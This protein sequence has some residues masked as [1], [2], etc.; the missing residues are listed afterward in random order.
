MG[1]KNKKRKLSE[2]D[3]SRRFSH[4]P[5][6]TAC[7]MLNLGRFKDS[8]F[9]RL[10]LEAVQSMDTELDWLWERLREVHLTMGIE[11]WNEM[12]AREFVTP[13]LRSVVLELLPEFENLIY[14]EA[15][16]VGLDKEGRVD[17]IIKSGDAI[18]LVI[19]VKATEINPG[20][21]QN[22]AQIAAARDQNLRNGVELGDTMF[23]I[24]TTG[25]DWV[26]MKVVF[27]AD[28]KPAVSVSKGMTLSIRC[29][30]LSKTV[31]VKEFELLRGRIMRMM[32][33]QAEKLQGSG[34]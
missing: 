21:A 32:K 1:R 14:C 7:G 19:E 18:L 11:P 22:L 13:V 6:Q 26:L 27:G 20:I 4:R 29:K 33:I 3:E 2:K 8:N 30:E 9:G 17:L 10:N 28:N 15:S 34:S 12:I 16:V 25:Y 31:L 5:A 23:G 24:A